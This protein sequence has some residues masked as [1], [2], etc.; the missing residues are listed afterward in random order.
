MAVPLSASADHLIL[1]A[2]AGGSLAIATSTASRS[3]KDPEA[4]TR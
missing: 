2:T 3:L 1:L 4:A